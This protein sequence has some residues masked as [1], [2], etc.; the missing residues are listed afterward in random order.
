MMTSPNGNISALLALCEGNPPVT[1]G[2][3]SQRSVTRSFHTFFDV[4][5]KR[6][7]SKQPRCWWFEAPLHISWRHCFVTKCANIELVEE[8]CWPHWSYPNPIQVHDCMF[9]G[10]LALSIQSQHQSVHDRE[11][12]F[13]LLTLCMGNPQVICP[14]PNRGTVKRSFDANFVTGLNNLLNKSSISRYFD[15]VWR[16][17]DVTI[18][19]M[20]SEADH[21]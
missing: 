14:L 17:Y 21:H 16:S 15:T 7:L 10:Q 13:S 6:M 20:L 19:S 11:T 5:L 1:G 18:L 8:T 9:I 4:R 3:P 12:Y 2:F